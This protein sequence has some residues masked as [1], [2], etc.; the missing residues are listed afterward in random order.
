LS[1]ANVAKGVA[2][3]NGAMELSDGT[4]VRVEGAGPA[5]IF[6]HGIGLDHSIFAGQVSAF[7][8]SMTT[9]A[10]DIVGHGRSRKPQ[11]EHSISLYLD[12][13]CLVMD[14]LSLDRPILVGFS[15]G[16]LIAR[17]FAIRYPERLAGLALMNTWFQRTPKETRKV[18]SRLSQAATA[19]PA[20]SVAP[21]LERWFSEAY[22]VSS[23]ESLKNIADILKANDH[24]SFISAY[25]I[26]AAQ[27]TPEVDEV[28]RITC[29][30]IV[31]TGQEDR[32]NS[33][34]M[35]MR[36]SENIEGSDLVILP[37]LRHMA[38]VEDAAVV[39]ATLA[40]LFRRVAVG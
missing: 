27:G 7:R 20:V 26:V 19:G 5:A 31:I 16:S 9:V 24:H 2:A 30:T 35:S 14:E 1:S 13:L 11:V 21:A 28:D 15:L 4:F 33:P 10:Y 18:L 37:G 3:A 25:A 12:Q 40:R 23:P 17:A 29:P 22:R 6:L 39:N 34:G 38:L 32:G 36:V 8:H